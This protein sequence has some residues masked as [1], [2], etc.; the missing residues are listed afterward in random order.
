M[1]YADQIGFLERILK[2]YRVPLYLVTEETI[3]DY[4]YD[5]GLRQILGVEEEYKQRLLELIRICKDNTI[6]GFTDAF[7]WV[8]GAVCVVVMYKVIMK[9]IPEK[10]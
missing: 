4:Q 2:K 6:Y 5:L 1:N 3:D 9:K 7:A 8:A 10:A